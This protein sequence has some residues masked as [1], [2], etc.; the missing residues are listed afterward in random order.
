MSRESK[1][2]NFLKDLN[3]REESARQNYKK[4]VNRAR[5]ISTANQVIAGIAL[6]TG[7]T[8]IATALTVV[9]LPVTITTS[10]IS[11][12]TG[13]TSFILVKIGKSTKADAKKYNQII[14]LI[15]ECKSKLNQILGISMNS[16]NQL[17][18]QD[19]INAYNIYNDYLK[20]LKNINWEIV[21][22]ISLNPEEPL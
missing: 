19:F 16:Q 4:Y 17:S 21:E 13:I 15:T 3:N 8:S 7:G 14:H 10:V 9:G 5:D 2:L 18:D 11:G 20:K 6:T 1:V 22:S 12:I